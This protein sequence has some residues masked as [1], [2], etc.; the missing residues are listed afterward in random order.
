MRRSLGV[1]L[2][3]SLPDLPKLDADLIRAT[4]GLD[5]EC[6]FPL[7]K[8]R[9]NW[10]GMR[11]ERAERTMSR[12]LDDATTLLAQSQLSR[13]AERDPNQD[14][15]WY[16][17]SLNALLRF[18]GDTISLMETRRLVATRPGIRD[19]EVAWGSTRPP[20][21]ESV[22]AMRV[23]IMYG[24]EIQQETVQSTPSL[25]HGTLRLSRELGAGDVHEFRTHVRDL[26]QAEP[27]Y[28]VTPTRR[29]DRFE[30]RLKFDHDWRPKRIC[31]LDGTLARFARDWPLEPELLVPDEIGEVTTSFMALRRGRSYGLLWT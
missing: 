30:L 5:A 15:D 12:R 6:Q 28:I 1:I 8:D 18:E 26:A 31:R 10:A 19:V 7:L 23:E 9:L 13:A 24:G 21:A 20:G 3:R 11:S 25:W 4:L 27:Y 16:L 29:V 14:D 17:S 22:D 2:D